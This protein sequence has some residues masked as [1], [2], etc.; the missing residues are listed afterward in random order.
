LQERQNSITRESLETLTGRETVVLL[1]RP[2]KRQEAGG[3]S[4]RGKDPGGR[5]VNVHFE[6]YAEDQ[7]LGGKLVKV[8]I[9]EAKNHSLVGER[10]GEP[11]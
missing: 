7:K 5:V 8:K 2:S 6:G 3:M 9:I 4:W 1:E 11:W 10:M